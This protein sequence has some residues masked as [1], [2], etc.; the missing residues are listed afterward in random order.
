MGQSGR[1]RLFLQLFLGGCSGGTAI[2]GGFMLERLFFEEWEWWMW[3][4]AMI[5]FVLGVLWSGWKISRMDERQRDLAEQS[6]QIINFN[7]SI[8]AVHI[9]PTGIHRM[10]FAGSGEVISPHP[11]RVIDVEVGERLG[12][13]DSVKATLIPGGQG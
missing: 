2:V 13:S 6:P 4:I 8:G 9:E 12:I 1:M 10:P 3:G 5:P 11:V 7:G